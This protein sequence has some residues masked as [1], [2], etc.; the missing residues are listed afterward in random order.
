MRETSV[1]FAA[2]ISVFSLKESLGRW[3]IA[4]AIAFAGAGGLPRL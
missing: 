4:A 1:I 2:T 3:R